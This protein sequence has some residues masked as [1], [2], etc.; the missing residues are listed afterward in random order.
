MPSRSRVRSVF[1]NTFCE[2]PSTDRRNCANR[3]VT[4]GEA[5]NDQN[6]PFVRD[7]I[8]YLPR[9]T[10]PVKDAPRRGGFQ[11]VTIA[12]KSAYLSLDCKYPRMLMGEIFMHVLKVSILAFAAT[13]F[14][15]LSN[16]AQAATC[17]RPCLLDQATLFNTAM[18]GHTPE[19]IRLAPDAQIRENTKAIALGDSRWIG[20]T[21]ILSKGVYADAA[22]GTVIEHVAAETATGK[23]VYI[24]TRLKLI[25]GNITEVEINFDDSDRVNLKNLVPYDPVFDTIVPPEARASREKLERI[26]TSYFKG[27]TDHQPIQ[28]DYDPRCDRYHSGNRVTHN[29]RNGVE[30]SGDVGCYESNLGPKPWGPATEIR[31]GL[32]DPERGIVIGY[33]IL[34]YGDSLRRM[35]INEV[36]KILDDR[37][38]MVDNIGLMEERITTSGFTR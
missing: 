4:P 26:I 19:K 30:E 32:I 7:A 12:H 21:K 35:Q 5:A 34:Y 15:V 36:F 33:A 20:V 13:A 27:L 31:I 16:S 8:Q 9:W 14:L 1:V 28:A 37:I 18:L 3:S 38:R 23:P 24:G 10:I 11:K 29:P 2:I 25:D 6:C 17:D 22:L